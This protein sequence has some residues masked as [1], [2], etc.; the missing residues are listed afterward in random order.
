MA[1][2]RRGTVVAVKLLAAVVASVLL[3]CGGAQSKPFDAS[4]RIEP[5]EP[6]GCAGACARVEECWHRQ[7][8]QADAEGDR[9]ECETRCQA[10]TED[11]Q[12][13][14]AEAMAAETSCPKIL[15]M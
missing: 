9:A 12:R 15:D 14:Y 10:R 2:R 13:A 7:Y 5:G 6:A 11:E 4:A 3:G 8:G 1:A